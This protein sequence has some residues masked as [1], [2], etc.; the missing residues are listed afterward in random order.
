MLHTLPFFELSF[1][2]NN[3]LDDQ[4]YHVCSELVEVGEAMELGVMERVAEE[5]AD[6]MVSAHTMLCIIERD[7]GYH[8]IDVLVRVHEKN[9]KRGYES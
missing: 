1:S 9:R 5:V 3:N 7:Y 2:K 8:P 4:F 6:V